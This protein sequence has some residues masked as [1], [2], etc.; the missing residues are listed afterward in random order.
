[1]VGAKAS[2]QS[3]VEEKDSVE[4]TQQKHLGEHPEPPPSLQ[5]VTAPIASKP[6]TNVCWI[7][8]GSRW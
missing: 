6:D 2:L 1:M 4:A 7:G 3:G 8:S 5:L